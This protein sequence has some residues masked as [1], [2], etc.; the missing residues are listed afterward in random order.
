M[1]GAAVVVDEQVAIKRRKRGLAPSEA[2][3]GAVQPVGRRRRALRRPGGAARGRGVGAAAGARTAGAADRARLPRGVQ[4]GGAGFVAGRQG[5]GARRGRAV[6][7]A[8]AGQPAAGG[9]AAGT[10][11]QAVATLDVDATILESQ[12]RSALPTYDGRSGYQPVVALWAEQDVIL[13]D[14][15]RD[16]NVPAGSG[17]RRVVS[18]LWPLCR[19]GSMRSGCGAT[20]RSTNNRCCAGWK[21]AGSATRSAP[22]WAAS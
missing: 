18:K 15:F 22:T 12:K 1:S 10:V 5:G 3:R 13:A 7:R 11:P 14:E 2:G 21:R 17:N 20:A 9:L 8:D 19:A 4:R 16:G 6:A